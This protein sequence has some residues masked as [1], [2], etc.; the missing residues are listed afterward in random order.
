MA[1][2]EEAMPTLIE[3]QEH[4][5]DLPDAMRS[6]TRILEKLQASVEHQDEN[7]AVLHRSLEPLD[8]SMGRLDGD[9]TALHAALE[10]LGRLAERLPGGRRSRP[11]T[12]NGLVSS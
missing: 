11:T 12:A 10:P 8:S 5:A 4:L 6:M 1:T 9:V 7:V 3:V 2:I